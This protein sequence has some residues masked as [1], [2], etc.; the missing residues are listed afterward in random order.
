[1]VNWAI[2]IA[3]DAGVSSLLDHDEDR[4]LE[5]TASKSTSTYQSFLLHA[6]TVVETLRDGS[7]WDVEYPRDIW[8]LHTLP[9]LVPNPG[10][11]AGA[12]NHLRFD[13]I[14]QPWLR[15]LA[16]R[17]CRLRLTAGSPSAPLLT[18][19][20]V[21]IRFSRFLDQ[22]IP[23]VDAL[24]GID[25]PLLERYLAWIADELDSQTMKEDAVTCINTFFRAIRQHG[26][27]P[28][29]PTTA[30][31]FTGDS[32]RRPPRESRRLSEHVM[33]QVEAPANLDRWP[34][35]Q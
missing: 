4:W 1:M 16:K 23:T 12:R 21:L 13:R 32:P 22:R 17:W 11:I 19:M 8:R 31:F 35:P 33:A 27:D 28:T 30:V 7:G 29:L 26:W 6:R 25:R 34:H 15:D 10:K 9:G 2:R 24:A 3:G 5:I 14:A 20:N 18:D